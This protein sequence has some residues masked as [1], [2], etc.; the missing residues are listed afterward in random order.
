MVRTQRTLFNLKELEGEERILEPMWMMVLMYLQ[1]IYKINVL[2]YSSKLIFLSLMVR[3]QRTLFN[4]KELE[5]EKRILEPMWEM[6]RPMPL[7]I[8]MSL[9]PS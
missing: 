9:G 1:Y 7:P 8:M 2:I 6:G 4:L 5:D 3:T